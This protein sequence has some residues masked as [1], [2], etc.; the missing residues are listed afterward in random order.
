[1]TSFAANSPPSCLS[2]PARSPP[3]TSVSSAIQSA[4]CCGSALPEKIDVVYENRSVVGGRD[5]LCE[6]QRRQNKVLIG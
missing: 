2:R 6:R 3:D 1:M 4:C 5:L